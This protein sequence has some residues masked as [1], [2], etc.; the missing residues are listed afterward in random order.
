MNLGVHFDRAI[1][2]HGSKVAIIDGDTTLSYRELG[3]RATRLANALLRLGVEKGERAAILTPNCHEAIE[4]D[5]ALFKTGI[6]KVPL[7][8][9]ISAREIHTM[10]DDSATSVIFVHSALAHVVI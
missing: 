8:A 2:Q 5:A 4:I 1:R 7:N 9:R 3:R 6:I 10:I